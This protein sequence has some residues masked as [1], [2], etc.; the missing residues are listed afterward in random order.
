MKIVLDFRKPKTKT[1][2]DETTEGEGSFFGSIG[3]DTGLMDRE[4]LQTQIRNIF[5]LFDDDES[6][7]LDF[8]EVKEGL[9]RFGVKMPDE[10]L[11]GMMEKVGAGTS[12]ECDAAQF[13]N[14]LSLLKKS[15]TPPPPPPPL[16]PPPPEHEESEESCS[17]SSSSC[18]F[19]ED[20]D[21]DE[22]REDEFDLE[23]PPTPPPP[24]KQRL[25]SPRT[26]Q[27]FHDDALQTRLRG[28]ESNLKKFIH[29]SKISKED[30]F[31][32]DLQTGRVTYI[33]AEM[34]H[35]GA[36]YS[37]PIGASGQPEGVGA[38]DYRKIGDARGRLTAERRS[39]FLGTVVKGKRQVCL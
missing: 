8:S 14:L 21:P 33:A 23:L 31:N 25:R 37:G 26:T 18:S 30:A 39:Y 20:E 27:V 38:L 4:E 17:S 5:E 28:L 29:A 1:L 36:L 2:D 32:S 34:Q 19:D 24:Q 11:V 35:N 15:E 7:L 9:E 12:M 6:G 16:S 22:F 3:L 10:D 13:E